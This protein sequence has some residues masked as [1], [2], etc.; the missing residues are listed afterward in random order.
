MV[1]RMLRGDEAGREGGAGCGEGRR[2]DKVEK[3]E[4]NGGRY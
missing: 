3:E 2:D 4:R 1:E